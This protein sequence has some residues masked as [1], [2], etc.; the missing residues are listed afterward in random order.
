VVRGVADA[1]DDTVP[2]P[3]LLMAE[4]RNVYAVPLV[5]P[6]AVY[7]AV[8]DPVSAVTVLQVSP[9]VLDST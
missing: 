2:V 1:V 9:S 5:K 7:D 6:V 8:D 3:T 4:A